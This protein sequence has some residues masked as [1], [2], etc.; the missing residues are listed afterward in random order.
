MIF[1]HMRRALPRRDPFPQQLENPLR[2]VRAERGL[3]PPPEVENDQ[4]VLAGTAHVERKPISRVGSSP[5]PPFPAEP[6]HR[7]GIEFLDLGVRDPLAR[8]EGEVIAT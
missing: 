3:H 6:S 2:A 1:L 8:G 5:A 4:G 7:S